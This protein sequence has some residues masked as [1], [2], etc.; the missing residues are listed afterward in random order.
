M[1]AMRRDARR[2]TIGLVLLCAARLVAAADC[3]SLQLTGATPGHIV[4]QR[5]A[6][7]SVELTAGAGLAGLPA[8]CRVIATLKPVPQ[9]EIQIEVWLPEQNWNGKLLG[10]GNG[11]FSGYI[12]FSALADGLKRGY[13]TVSTNTG[14][15]GG[16]GSFALGQPG[17][18]IDFGYRAVH[19]MTVAAKQLV[20][21]F[22]MRDARH[23]YF[24]GCSAGG[25]QAMQSA[26]R[27]PDDYDGIVAGSPGLDWTGR[28]ASALRVAQA[29]RATPDSMLDAKALALLHTAALAACD[30]NDGL[31]DG[32]IESPQQCHFDPQPLQCTADHSGDC[33]TPGQV[34]AARAIY[35]SPLNPA[36]GRAITGLYPGSEPGWNTWGGPTPLSMAFD[37]FRYV[38]NADPDWSLDQFRF[39]RDVARAEQQDGNTINALNPDLRRFFARGGKLLHYHG[40]ADPQ[41]SPGVSPQYFEAVRGSPGGARRVEDSYRLFMV[42][43]MAHCGGGD[44]ASSFDMIA[45]LEQWVEQG[46]APASIPAQRVRNGTVDRGRTLCPYPQVAHYDG[47]G[48][49]DAAASFRCANP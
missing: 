48:D 7:G 4:E 44:G 45:A 13:A 24:S 37:E 29:V 1:S 32:V 27:Y 46:K 8:F 47:H 12:A 38:V 2:F 39:D 19:E 36:T 21:D 25:R 17:K 23:A 15:D 26:Q 40:W 41:I 10:V 9:S 18:L 31:K 22:Y 3:G 30:A 14:H 49:P 5:V 16:S 20:H 33:L 6:S 28:A 34:A 43:G 35:A 11:G 42:P